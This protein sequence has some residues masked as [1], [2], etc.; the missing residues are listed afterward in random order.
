L[1]HRY[2]GVGQRLGAK[3]WEVIKQSDRVGI[4]MRVEKVHARRL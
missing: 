4:R 2:Q 3:R 1:E